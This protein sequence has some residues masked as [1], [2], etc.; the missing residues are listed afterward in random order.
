ML[1]VLSVFVGCCEGVLKSLKFSDMVSVGLFFIKGGV[2][3]LVKGVYVVGFFS[4]W[5]V[6]SS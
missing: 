4:S 5:I 2:S 6:S 1:C 3:G